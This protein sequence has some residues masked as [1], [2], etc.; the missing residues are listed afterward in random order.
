MKKFRKKSRMAAGAVGAAATV[1]YLGRTIEDDWVVGPISRLTALLLFPL[2]VFSCIKEGRWD[3]LKSDL[4]DLI[5]VL[6]P[7]R[8]HEPRSREPR[9]KRWSPAAGTEVG[10]PDAYGSSRGPFNPS[11]GDWMDRR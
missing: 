7:K 1:Y 10:L 11:S 2:G 5:I 8:W 3:D 9:I 4:K 6:G